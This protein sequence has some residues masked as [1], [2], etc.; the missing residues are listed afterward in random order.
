MTQTPLLSVFIPTCNG[1][2]YVREALESV[3][4]NGFADLEI[5]VL[6]DGSTDATI[7]IIESVRHPALHLT[8]NPQNLG[9][10]ETRRRGVPL[11]RGRYVAL[12]DQ[13]D[14]AVPGRFQAQVDR[15]ETAGGP[16]IVGGAIESFGDVQGVKHF[17]SSDAEI[18]A[19]L[20]FN[21]SLANPA[22]CMKVA[23]LRDGVIGYSGHA[24]RAAEDYALWVDAMLAGLKLE[25]LDRVVTRYRWHPASLT[26]TMF[27][28]LLLC[29][30]RIRR[31]VAAAYFPGFDDAE[32]GALVDAISQN[33][34][35]LPAWRAAVSALSHA[36]LSAGAIPR[37]DSALM[38][39]LLGE[40]LMRLIVDGLNRGMIDFSRL[41]EMV[42]DN[43]WFEQWRAADNGALDKRIMALFS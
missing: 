31:R 34:D 38:V 39:R 8:R 35:A 23:P 40:H 42:E 2:R 24:G 10:V 36:A 19:A 43:A 33:P 20:L 30:I 1:E 22:V 15:L 27:D 9:V 12:L 13:D 25:N 26:R 16:D 21:A 6:D 32:R 4:E 37:I 14:I 17:F 29:A 5:V 7:D 3:L 18:R 11:L 41:E 28:E